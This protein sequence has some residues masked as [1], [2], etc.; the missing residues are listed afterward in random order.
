MVL[1]Q[2]M[3][4]ELNLPVF[5]T[6][7]QC[8]NELNIPCYV[9]G[10]WVRD[11]ILNRPCKDL[12]FVSLGKGIDLAQ[13][14]AS[15][16]GP[17]IKVHIFKN[18]GTAQINFSDFDLEFVGARK[19]SYRHNSRKPLVENGSLADDQNR[20]DFTINAMAISLNNENYGE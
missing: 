10:G 5:K 17:G 14:V 7:S 20:R 3:Q 2:A 9:V 4:V 12:D 18:F 13:S 15:K 6:V 1:L 11:L 19:E 8:A 16:L